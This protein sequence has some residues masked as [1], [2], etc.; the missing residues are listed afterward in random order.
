M[1]AF[2]SLILCTHQSKYTQFIIFHLCQI[3]PKVFSSFKNVNQR[4]YEISVQ[5]YVFSISFASLD[6][7]SAVS[8]RLYIGHPNSPAGPSTSA[9][10]AKCC[11]IY[12]YDWEPSGNCIV[13]IHFLVASL[14]GRATA[15]NA[16]DSRVVIDTLAQ[17]AHGY[18]RS[19]TTSAMETPD[20]EKFDS[21]AS[22]AN[23]PLILARHSLYH[24][25]VQ[26]I[27]YI[28]C[29]NFADL[30]ALPSSQHWVS[31]LQIEGYELGSLPILSS[32]PR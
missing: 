21:C 14:C 4:T 3:N 29:F 9:A 1:N 7:P 27:L 6:H 12:W 11:G 25:V 32:V 28:F 19:H 30:M 16:E 10:K 18:L 26:A 31:D 20:A 24:I 23:E 13:N 22:C 15:V 5:V 17:W 8:R 2:D